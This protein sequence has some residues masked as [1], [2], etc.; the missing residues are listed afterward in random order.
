MSDN[1]KTVK[2]GFFKKSDIIVIGCLLA[3]ALASIVGL[4]YYQGLKQSEQ[5]WA[6]LTTPKQDYRIN[7][8]TSENKKYIIDLAVVSD[9][10][11]KLEINN[12]QI[13]FIDVDCPDHICENYGFLSS[14]YDI[15]VCMPNQ[16]ALTVYNNEEIQTKFDETIELTP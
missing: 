9:I 11:A 8:S 7:L 14:S 10:P 1:N 12:C 15:A 13:R 2:R 5:M 16:I 3:I 6:I 4:K